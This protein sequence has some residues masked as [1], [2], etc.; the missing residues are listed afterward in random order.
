MTDGQGC[1]Y[2][3]LETAQELLG[4]TVDCI[5]RRFHCYPLKIAK[6]RD[7]RYFVVDR[8]NVWMPINEYDQIPFDYVAGME[9]NSESTG[10]C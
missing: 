2:I 9:Y 7:G 10:E 3:T 1:N 8:N 4:K 6:S 5:K